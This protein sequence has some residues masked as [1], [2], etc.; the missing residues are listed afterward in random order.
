MRFKYWWRNVFKN[1]LCEVTQSLKLRKNSRRLVAGTILLGASERQETKIHKTWSFRQPQIAVRQF[2]RRLKV[3]GT[4]HCQFSSSETH[5]AR[6]LKS[7]HSF[8]GR[9]PALQGLVSCKALQLPSH[10]WPQSIGVRD[11]IIRL[12]QSDWSSTSVA[13][14]TKIE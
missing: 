6:S 11:D 1:V 7:W 14:G 2:Y 8:A 5:T 13:L 3:S 4:S 9:S 12:K 10:L